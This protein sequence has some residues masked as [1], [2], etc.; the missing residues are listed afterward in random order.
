MA[1]RRFSCA[2][3]TSLKPAAFSQLQDIFVLLN[4]KLLHQAVKPLDVQIIPKGCAW[5]MC[6]MFCC[7]GH[8]S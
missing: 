5:L 6:R 8:F 1:V 2:H 3:A 4:G 7:L